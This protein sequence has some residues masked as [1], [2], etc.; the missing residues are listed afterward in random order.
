MQIQQ[1]FFGKLLMLVIISVLAYVENANAFDGSLTESSLQA[2]SFLYDT[3]TLDLENRGIVSIDSSAFF[4]YNDVKKLD[5]SNN[6]ISS[7]AK[8]AFHDLLY[9]EEI[10][11]MNNNLVSLTRGPFIGLINLKRLNFEGNKLITV[12]RLSFVGLISLIDLCFYNNPAS[13]LFPENLATLCG[14]NLNCTVSSRA[15]CAKQIENDG[16]IPVGPFAGGGNK[17][18][19]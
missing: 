2:W 1:A 4:K 10:S 14:K 3:E 11:L 6:E 17:H 19:T 12:D 9:I 5:L 8:D 15:S 16:L 18:F 13:T 7:L